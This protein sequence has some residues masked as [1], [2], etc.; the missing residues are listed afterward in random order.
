MKVPPLL[1]LA[2]ETVSLRGLLFNRFT[3]L[4]VVLLVAAV[5]WQGY[6]AANS[7]GNVTGTVVDADGDPVT[8]ATVTLSP[9]TVASVP[10]PQSTTTDENGEFAFRDNTHLEFTLQAT[11]GDLG[12]SDTERYHL[13]FEGQSKDV[14]LVIEN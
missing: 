11:H 7:D 10:S 2:R 3:I 6:V 9:Q 14:T 12:E 8:N 5:A 4:V 1:K 13:Y